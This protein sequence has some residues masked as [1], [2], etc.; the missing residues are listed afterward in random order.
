MMEHIPCPTV[1]TVESRFFSSRALPSILIAYQPYT[2]SPGP[3]AQQRSNQPHMTGMTGAITSAKGFVSR[4][5]ARY[6]LALR[7]KPVRTR[8][9]SSGVLYFVGDHVAQYGIED[10]TWKGDDADESFDVS[11][12]CMWIVCGYSVRLMCRVSCG[13]RDSDLGEP[14]DEG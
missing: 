5:W 13:R 4:V 9:A 14:C 2:S 12:L 1:Y 11:D 8:M 3:T 10:R 7:E 6:S